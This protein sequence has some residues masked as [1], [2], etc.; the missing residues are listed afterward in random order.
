MTLNKSSF[1]L[2]ILLTFSLFS[3]RNLGEDASDFNDFISKF[4][5]L[6][7]EI[8][9]QEFQDKIKSETNISKLYQSVTKQTVYSEDTK[10]IPI[11]KIDTKKAVIIIYGEVKA[12]YNKNEQDLVYINSLALDKKS[13]AFIEGSLLQYLLVSGEIKRKKETYIANLKYDGETIT[14]ENK[15]LNQ[16]DKSVKESEVAVYRVDKKMLKFDSN[17]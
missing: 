4:P 15:T 13:G 8:T 10:F 17:K 16:P 3:F 6:D 9:N 11:G 14:F 1:L 5:V 7:K 2:S 12:A